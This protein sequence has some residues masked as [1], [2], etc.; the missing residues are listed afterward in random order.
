MLKTK[1][2]V[3]GLVLLCA[4]CLNVEAKMFKWVDDNGITH[5]GETIP[6]EYANKD[7]TEL[8]K[9]GEVEKRTEKP[10]LEARRAKE[11]ED[12]KKN[13]EQQATIEAKRRDSALLSTFSNE[14]E[15][16]E[17]S[18]RNSLQVEARI[19]SIKTM[20]EIAKGDLAGHL[21]EK[22]NFIN[23]NKPID[24]TLTQDISEDQAKIDKLQT[25]LVQSEQDLAKVHAR[26]DSDK[27]R[28]RELKNA[29]ANGVAPTSPK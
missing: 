26:F 25:E 14:K 3:T 22:D 24:P 5:Y 20:L 6:P 12:A 21:K 23:Q 9:N 28:F 13:A 16:D 11:K 7:T 29:N 19:D 18:K 17:A 1:L 15:I 10:T 27:Q 8:N 2:M 4:I